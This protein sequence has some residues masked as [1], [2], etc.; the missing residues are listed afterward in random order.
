ME[1]EEIL[2]RLNEFT[3]REMSEDEVY[4]F[5]VILCDNDIDRDGERFLRTRW[6]A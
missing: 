3:R 5:D 2:K 1:K 4:I 6:K